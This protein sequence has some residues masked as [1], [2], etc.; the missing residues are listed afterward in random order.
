[1]NYKYFGLFL[2]L[3]LCLEMVVQLQSQKK[4]DL[5]P[6]K[7]KRLVNAQIEKIN[8]H[9]M[10]MVYTETLINKKT[11]FVKPEQP[12]QFME[13]LKA[14]V[15]TGV[16]FIPEVGPALSGM[17]DTIWS[18]FIENTPIN[19][20][21]EDWYLA[22]IRDVVGDELIKFDISNSLATL[23]GLVRHSQDFHT[24]VNESKYNSSQGVHDMIKSFYFSLD[25][26]LRDHLAGDF[27]RPGYELG[28][29]PSYAIAATIYFMLQVEFNR[30]ATEWGYEENVI[31]IQRQIAFNVMPIYT[32]NCMAI[33]QSTL[34]KIV[35]T[36][37]TDEPISGRNT[38]EKI[39]ALRRILI[40]AV[41][42]YVGMWW[43]MDSVM[44]P[45]GV[46]AERVRKVWGPT[47]GYARDIDAVHDPNQLDPT[48]FDRFT[49][50]D[51]TYARY[52]EIHPD[53][54]IYATE[55]SRNDKPP[56]DY[57]GYFIYFPK[58]FRD[59]KLTMIGTSVPK[60]ISNDN[61]ENSFLLFVD[62][63][64]DDMENCIDPQVGC[65]TTPE[66]RYNNF[67][68]PFHKVGDIVAWDSNNV[69]NLK[70]EVT[71]ALMVGFVPT[72]VFHSN[73]VF[74]HTTTAIDAQKFTVK[75]GGSIFVRDHF[76]I[77]SH[78]L[79]IPT[80]N[81]LSYNFI[82]QDNKGSDHYLG[83]LACL[84]T[85]G[86]PVTVTITH[87]ILGKVC[88]IVIGSTDYHPILDINQNLV[89]L[90]SAGLNAQSPKLVIS[91]TGDFYLK[92]IIFVPWF[93]P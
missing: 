76:T 93:S 3:V 79:M 2:L 52:M 51:I 83:I 84:K 39:L 16:S 5:A 37:D 21:N 87:S 62:A 46:Y 19:D 6:T 14:Y 43:Q 70:Y 71:D 68:V 91:A 27:N 9:K 48:Y 22:G 61:P 75:Q 88:D 36:E 13:M 11:Y 92:S 82:A 32:N 33:F 85:A 59:S 28:E 50:P 80:G 60:Y 77:G 55:W 90:T 49:G 47:L 7:P 34:A 38:F 58:T 69:I 18:G 17:I 72:N 8:W 35:A 25:S 57:D 66:E 74:R 64:S 4:K 67:K 63:Y 53:N 41:F 20:F 40:L 24:Y 29:L 42:D 1:M 89:R 23:Q 30:H 54:I 12:L 15:I 26:G 65:S 78:A 44:F 73:T 10:M 81:V 45:M 86:A 31:C 56:A